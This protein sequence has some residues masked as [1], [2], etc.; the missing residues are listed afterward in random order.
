MVQWR[1]NFLLGGWCSAGLAPGPGKSLSG[2]T[3]SLGENTA[4]V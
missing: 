4:P 2:N 1:E 3:E